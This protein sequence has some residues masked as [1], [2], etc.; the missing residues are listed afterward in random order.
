M[1]YVRKLRSHKL[2]AYQY[3]STWLNESSHVGW[4]TCFHYQA[5]GVVA[6]HCTCAFKG[7]ARIWSSN[8]CASEVSTRRFFAM[9][10]SSIRGE[11]HHDQLELSQME[12]GH[13]KAQDN[14]SDPLKEMMAGSTMTCAS[15]AVLCCHLHAQL[16]SSTLYVL[17]QCSNGHFN[18][19][20]S[21]AL[22]RGRIFLEC[23]T[24][25]TN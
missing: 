8:T 23:Y 22:S 16:P 15:Q 24:G 1:M 19:T 6:N 3:L 2:A 10:A 5:A 11:E 13:E 14:A 20:Q 17:M 4:G 7:A 18:G 25:A 9:T 21:C 12:S